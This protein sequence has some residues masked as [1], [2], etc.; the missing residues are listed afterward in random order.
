MKIFS[1]KDLYKKAKCKHLPRCGSGC[2][3]GNLKRWFAKKHGIVKEKYYDS[4]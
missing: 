4:Q 1:K 2:I 3:I